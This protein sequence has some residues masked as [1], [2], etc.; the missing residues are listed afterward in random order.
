MSTQTDSSTNAIEEKKAEDTGST[1]KMDFKGFIKNYIVSIV[2]T[3]GIGVFLIGTL[4]LYS[5]KVAQANV[6]PTDVNL[7]PFTDVNRVVQELPIDMNAVGKMSQKAVFDSQ[8]YLASFKDSILCSLKK[9]AKPTSGFFANG[10]LFFSK[11][12]DNIFAKV[13]EAVTN[14]FLYMSYLPEWLTMI[15]YSLFGIFI[16]FG[17]YVYTFVVSMFYHVLNI[18]ELFRDSLPNDASTWEASSDISMIRITK[19]LLFFFV[20]IPVGFMSVIFSPIYATLNGLIAPLTAKYSVAGVENGKK[21]S[22]L[23]FIKDTLFYKKSLFVILASL[24]LA[25]NANKYLG[26][27]ALVG[28]LVAIIVAYFMGLYKSTQG[29]PEDGFTDGFG[30]PEHLL[31][32]AQGQGKNAICPTIKEV[33]QA[34]QDM[35]TQLGGGSRGKKGLTKRYNVRL[36]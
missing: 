6:M 19:A 14:I 15:L 9:S 24:S 30:N 22:V 12:Y 17:L 10:A 8:D 1:N 29:S 28:V 5:T 33:K 20:W 36:V 18:P 35:G 31:A 7:A 23:D 21:H 25:S 13:Y 4:G 27:V 2:F 34:E 26:S 32:K 16:W 11:V 3:I